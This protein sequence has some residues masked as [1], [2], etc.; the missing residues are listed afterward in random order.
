VSV[1]KKCLRDRAMRVLAKLPPLSAGAS[2]FLAALARRD[3]DHDHLVAIIQRDPMLA[4]RVLELANSGAFG[5]LHRVESITRAVVLLG[6]STLRRHGI[7]WTVGGL[8]KGLP[9]LPRWSTSRYTTHA[10]ATALLADVLCDHL[11]IGKHG[12]GAFI[13][14]LVHDIGKFA[15]CAEASET[16]DHI[17]TMRETSPESTS[18]IERDVLGIDHAEISSMAAEKWR[19]GDDVCQAIYFH[20][21][22]QRDSEHNEIALSFVLSKSDAFVNGLGMNFLSPSPD[23]ANALHWPE[24]SCEV[25]VALQSFESVLMTHGVVV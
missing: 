20:H 7:R 21:E 6:P 2:A 12:D 16:I 18:Q 4:P 3:V 23:A 10:E 5:R 24:Y 17:L 8:L 22:P 25:E 11:P 14:G 1:S 15:I 9:D 13:A 19:L